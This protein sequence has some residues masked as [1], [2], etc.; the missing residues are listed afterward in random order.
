MQ[1]ITGAWLC[2]YRLDH[3]RV[4]YAGVT[5]SDENVDDQ[6]PNELCELREPVGKDIKDQSADG[7]VIGRLVFLVS[8]VVIYLR[9]V[10]GVDAAHFVSSAS[11]LYL[12]PED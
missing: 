11:S 12:V 3:R 6:S 2:L 4:F 8:I 10:L 7:I 9:V 5:V 1:A